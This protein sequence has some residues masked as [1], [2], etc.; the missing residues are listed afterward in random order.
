MKPI[1]KRICFLFFLLILSSCVCENE[2]EISVYDTPE[3]YDWAER[4]EETPTSDNQLHLFLPAHTSEA[5]LPLILILPGGCYWENTTVEEGINW[6]PYILK[7]GYA[8]AVLEYNFPYGNPEIPIAHVNRTIRYLKST[9]EFNINPD[10]IGIM[11][12][13]AGGHL[14]SLIS[15]QAAIE[16]RPSFQI[17]FYPPISM[18]DKYANT[19]THKLCRDNLMGTNAASSL[20]ESYSSNLHIDDNTPPAFIAA[21]DSDK[22]ISI[23]NAYIY[24]KELNDHNIRNTFMIAPKG[25]HGYLTWT[26][27]TNIRQTLREWLTDQLSPL[28]IPSTAN[29]SDK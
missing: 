14:A 22:K 9:P 18:E 10:N 25:G 20:K 19:D 8:A 29:V 6:V 28:E 12:F 7:L 17:L 5:S 13:S 11:G 4:Y 27:L 15:T 16:C 24:V 21:G 2:P 3:E 1:E 26:N 23:E